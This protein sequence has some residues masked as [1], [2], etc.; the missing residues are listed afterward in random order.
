MLHMLHEPRVPG[1]LP[2]ATPTDTTE[3]TESSLSRASLY[4]V[5]SMRETTL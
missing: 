5:T 3:A 4:L 1:R 2:I